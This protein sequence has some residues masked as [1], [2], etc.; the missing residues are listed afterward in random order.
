MF[1][2]KDKNIQISEL[3]EQRQFVIGTKYHFIEW[4]K[5]KG[6][7]F[8]AGTSVKWTDK[9]DNK[10]YA[11]KIDWLIIYDG[12]VDVSIAKTGLGRIPLK[13]LQFVK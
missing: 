2:P 7:T 12:D 11:G 8:K 1:T 10:T 3:G 6:K 9:D 5:Y 4:A 13:E